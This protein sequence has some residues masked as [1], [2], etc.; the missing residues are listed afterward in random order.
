M[1]KNIRRQ[2]S[3]GLGGG[4]SGWDRGDLGVVD[5]L[6]QMRQLAVTLA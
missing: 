4:V 6:S 3:E 2:P 5:V 1:Q